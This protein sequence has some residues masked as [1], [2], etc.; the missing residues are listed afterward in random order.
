MT[1]LSLF[2]YTKK[3]DGTGISRAVE[4]ISCVAP[5]ARCRL[6]DRLRRAMIPSTDKLDMMLS[7]LTNDAIENMLPHEPI[8]PIEK[9]EPTDP[10]DMN[11]FLHPIHSTE[12]VDAMLHLDDCGLDIIGSYAPNGTQIFFHCTAWRKNS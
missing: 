2:D 3:G 1:I 9:M 11:E 5:Y 6:V 4:R 7:T 10:I 12:L 8:D